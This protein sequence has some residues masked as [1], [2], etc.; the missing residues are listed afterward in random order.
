MASDTDMCFHPHHPLSRAYEGRNGIDFLRSLRV[1]R[2]RALNY[3]IFASFLGLRTTI[4]ALHAP[5]SASAF[6]LIVL[7]GDVSL[8]QSRLPPKDRSSA[9]IWD[10]IKWHLSTIWASRYSINPLAL[11]SYS[12][13]HRHNRFLTVPGPP[14]C[15][16]PALPCS[17]A[18]PVT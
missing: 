10:P 12:I 14:F 11:S 16:L 7:D 8:P 6:Y 17:F 5:G 15:S 4:Y 3:I 18:C 9:V 1:I 2:P 13:R